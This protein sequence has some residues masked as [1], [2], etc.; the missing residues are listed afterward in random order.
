[1]LGLLEG[2]WN[3]ETP[4]H[5]TWIDPTAIIAIN[6]TGTLLQITYTRGV[7]RALVQH[8]QRPPDD[9]GVNALV[10]RINEARTA[11]FG[12]L[13]ALL[14]DGEKQL[15][16][17]TRVMVDAVMKPVV[18]AWRADFGKFHKELPDTLPGMIKPALERMLADNET[19]RTAPP[20]SGA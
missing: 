11:A 3:C 5:R 14:L 6:D 16:Q 17:V 20:A 13:G 9:D 19:A 7:D 12:N 2:F 8:I 18:K 1:M 4:P 15:T 10:A